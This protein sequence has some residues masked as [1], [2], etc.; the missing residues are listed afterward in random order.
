MDKIY[1]NQGH[2]FL[3]KE[4]EDFLKFLI[5]HRMLDLVKL[6][7]IWQGAEHGVLETK[8]I[9]YKLLAGI[10]GHLSLPH[11]HF[12]LKKLCEMPAQMITEGEIDFAYELSKLQ[13]T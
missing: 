2:E 6:A 8:L 5:Y 4:S 12:L 3:V 9:I 7:K 13:K 10:S 1:G 11:I